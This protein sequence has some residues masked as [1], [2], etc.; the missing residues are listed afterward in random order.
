[1]A[2]KIHEVF[3][4]EVVHVGKPVLPPMQLSLL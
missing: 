4:I 2:N 1:V 3:N